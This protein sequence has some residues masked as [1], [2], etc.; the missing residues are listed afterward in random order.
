MAP[1]PLVPNP[2][3]GDAASAVAT[4]PQGDMIPDADGEILPGNDPQD[5]PG[6]RRPN[7]VVHAEADENR[8]AERRP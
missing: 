6:Q 5:G 4:P 8:D 1:D 3:G 2:A 7:K